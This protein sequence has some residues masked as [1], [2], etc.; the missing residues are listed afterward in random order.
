M[1]PPKSVCREWQTWQCRAVAARIAS[2]TAHRPQ[3]VRHLAGSGMPATKST[4]TRAV[5]D[6]VPLAKAKAARPRRSSGARRPNG[7]HPRS[8]ANQRRH[9]RRL[10]EGIHRAWLRGRPHRQH[11]PAGR[12]QQAHALPLFRQQGGALRRG[13]GKHLHGDTHRRTRLAPLRPRPWGGDAR[14]RSCSPGD[15]IWRIPSSSAFSTA[16]TCT[17]PSSSS[18]RRAS[19]R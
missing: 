4:R 15:T 6:A 14:P 13:A 19:S 7:Q 10:G 18:A 8:R 2:A 9:P 16:R 1:T 12:H 17:G 11:R 3:A 5:P